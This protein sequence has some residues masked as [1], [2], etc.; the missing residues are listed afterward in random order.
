MTEGEAVLWR[1]LRAKRPDAFKFR[2]QQPIGPYIADFVCHSAG[3]VIETDGSQ[4]IENAADIRRT[5]WLEAQRIRVLRF[6]NGEILQRPDDVAQA[7][8]A[9][10]IPPLPGPPPASLALS[11]EG[12][13]K[14]RFD[15]AV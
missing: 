7:I 10:L 15:H 1:L 5:A 8:Y 2:R 3:L 9:A 4:H 11:R 13:G 12:R 14:N 6:W